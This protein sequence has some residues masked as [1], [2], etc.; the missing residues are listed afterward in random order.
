[1]LKTKD[2][3]P[4]KPESL[5]ELGYILFKRP[6]VFILSAEIVIMGCGVCIIYFMLLGN[7]FGSVV[8]SIDGLKTVDTFYSGTSIQFTRTVY[9]IILSVILSPILMKKEL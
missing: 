3:C 4:G 7:T 5:Y 6:S 8:G 2:L 9:I 1:M